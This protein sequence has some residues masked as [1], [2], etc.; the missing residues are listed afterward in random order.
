[1]LQKPELLTVHGVMKTSL[2]RT[3]QTSAILTHCS[4]V[5]STP[6]GLWAHPWRI[7][8]DPSGAS[9]TN[10]K[11]S[12]EYCYVFTIF[13]FQQAKLKNN[14]IYKM[15]L[16]FQMFGHMAFFEGKDSRLHY[17]PSIMS[18]VRFQTIA[19]YSFIGI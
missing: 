4:G 7:T 5:A 9:C 8:H 18:D 6:V 3:S 11:A 14:I 17:G 15:L 10:S 12:N 2:I 16:Y 13:N 19:T 1:M